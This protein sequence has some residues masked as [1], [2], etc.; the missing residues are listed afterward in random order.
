MSSERARKC[1]RCIYFDRKSKARVFKPGD[2][3]LVLLPTSKNKLIMQW[4]RPFEVIEC[5]N[6]YNCILKVKGK[7]KKFHHNMLKLYYQPILCAMVVHRSPEQQ[8]ILD[9]VKGHYQSEQIACYASVVE[10]EEQGDYISSPSSI[11]TK[12]VED[13]IFSDGLTSTQLAELKDVLHRY[14]KIFSDI[15]KLAKVEPHYIVLT[16]KTPIHQ[17]P[18]PIPHKLTEAT[19]KEIDDKE[20]AGY[21]EPS[22]S[23]YCSPIVI[24]A[25]KDCGVRICGDFRKLNNKTQLDSEPMYYQ[26][27][28]FSNLSKSKVFSK[29]DLAKGFYQIPLHEES[30]PLTAFATPRGLYQFTVLPFGLTNSPAV[31]NKPM[32]KLLGMIPGV[33]IL[34]DDLLIHS[35]TWENHIRTLDLVLEKLRDSGLTVKPSKCE[36][37]YAEVEFLGHK[38]GNGKKW[39]QEAKLQK[40]YLASSP[41]TKKQLRSFLGLV[42]YYTEFIPNFSN[43]ALPLTNLTQKFQPNKLEWE[44][45]HQDAFTRLKDALFSKPILHLPDLSREFVLRTDNH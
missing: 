39:C 37:G 20:A 35:E 3:C 43:I 34:V 27:K 9:I 2:H 11:Q 28:L 44:Q 42:G 40:I 45:V 19:V 10:E 13:V 12:F 31:F 22:T 1:K 25:K 14:R 38:I 36:F 8:C 29:M 16:D 30:R 4:K 23:P 41:T 26:E 24:V 15:S 21:I 7:L 33:E 32:R 17:R 6:E 5:P 18:Y